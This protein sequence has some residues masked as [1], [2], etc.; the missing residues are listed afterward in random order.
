MYLARS[1]SSIN[2]SRALTQQFLTFAKGGAPI[3]KVENLFPF[4]Q[5]TTQFALSGSSVTCRFQIEEDLSPCDF[6][7][8]QIGQLV[9]NLILNAQQA[10]PDGGVID[11]SACNISLS[12]KEYQSHDAGN[13]VKLSIKDH[14][15]GIS[16]DLL[17]NIFDPYYTT[18][19][20]GHGFGLPTCYSIV[21]RHGGYIDVESELGKG[22]TFSVYLPAS[23]ESILII[24]GN[25]RGSDFCKH[26][27]IG[28]FL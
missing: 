28:T 19:P 12:A 5:E 25:Q 13:Y 18:N 26:E 9:D 2:R 11:V 27:G 3:K 4:V 24:P 17:P 10:M 16:K 7:K 1:I 6:D 21:N 20:N 8:I 23:T 22:S 14:G 15:I